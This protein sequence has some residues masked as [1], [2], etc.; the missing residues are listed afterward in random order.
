LVC[1][2][3]FYGKRKD[4]FGTVVFYDTI[5]N[6]VLL[7]KHVESEKSK[8][9]KELLTKLLSLG[10]T[11]N[12]VTIDDRRVLSTVFKAYPTQMCHFHQKKI[13]RKYITKNPKLDASKDLQKIIYLL[14]TTTTEKKFRTKLQKWHIKHHNFLNEMTVNSTTGEA[15]YTHY[16]L[17]AAHA[18]LT[19]HL[20]QLFIYK[21]KQH[22]SIPNT[23]NNLDGRLFADL[24]IRIKVHRGLSKK[25]KEKFV[26]Y[27]L[28]NS[29]KK[30]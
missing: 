15:T 28:L 13:I 26:D 19:S 16:R 10:Y 7:W 22:L 17:R 29:G 5:R 9:Y 3:T 18:S 4:K 14:T 8:H 12:G 1:D 2:T 11:I 23:T 21:N 27:Y 25:F 6:E 30:H 24:K 20:Y